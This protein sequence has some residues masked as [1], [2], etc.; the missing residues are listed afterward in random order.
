MDGC[1]F[2]GRSAAIDPRVV[3]DEIGIHSATMGALPPDARIA[4]LSPFSR[5]G[6]QIWHI[7]ARRAPAAARKAQD[8]ATTLTADVHNLSAEANGIQSKLAS[9]VLAAE[10]NLEST[11][12]HVSGTVKNFQAEIA[13][14]QTTIGRA[15][16][17]VQATIGQTASNAQA[18]IG[19]ATSNAQATI[20]QVTSNAHAAIN[21]AGQKA[22]SDLA[23]GKQ[24]VQATVQEAVG[25]VQAALEK[26]NSDYAQLLAITQIAQANQLPGGDATGANVQNGAYVLRIADTG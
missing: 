1:I 14:A 19:R 3:R 22:S 13:A 11:V 16:R 24:K 26:A 12:A 18:T 23:A 7:C 21:A 6:T 5:Q 4:S 2:P 9:D 20:G 15:T 10:R 17:N 8:A 25:T